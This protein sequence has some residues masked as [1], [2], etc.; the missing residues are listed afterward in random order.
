MA[1]GIQT[2]S[3]TAKQSGL[4]Q[5]KFSIRRQQ[6]VRL[7]YQLGEWVLGAWHPELLVLEPASFDQPAWPA[8]EAELSAL[9][10][11]ALDGLLCRKVPAAFCVPGLGRYGALLRY[12]SHR[13]VLHYVSVQGSFSDYLKTQFSPKPRQNLQR[14]VRRFA[15]RQDGKASWQVY[16]AAE[17]MEEFLREAVA[18]SKQT[19]QTR[20][21][22]AGLP[23]GPEFLKGIQR[24]AQDGRA[25]GY[26][27]RD[28]GK[29]IAFAWCRQQGN[30]LIYDT[31]GYLPEFGNLSPGSVLL[32]HIL[33]DVF[34]SA[35]YG[36]LDFGPGE[37]Q[38]KSLFATH[39]QEF[40][41]LY[42]LRSTL[43]NRI[44]LAGHWFMNQLS[45]AIGEI[46]ESYGVKKRVKAW[47]RRLK[48]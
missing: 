41:D 45:T 30:S 29:V 25:R 3:S 24:L 20:L 37:A 4:D 46:L 36:I 1:A 38:Y 44:L 33:E 10:T 48:A 15:E 8:S 26:L 6:T 31:I 23:S 19:Y 11:G 14:S 35:K 47:L 27:L 17:E 16:T 32:Y 5:I 34:A 39:S 13:D 2:G 12:V 21:L 18:V 22:D 9:L 42:L 40:V 7:K 43:K 28:Q